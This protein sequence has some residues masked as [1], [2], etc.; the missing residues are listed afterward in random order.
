MAKFSINFGHTL[1]GAGCGAEYKGFNESEITRA[2]GKELINILERKGHIVYNSTIDVA[3]SQN[4]YLKKAVEKVNNTDVDI[5]ISLHCNAS[6]LHTG[7]GVEVFTWNKTKHKEALNILE[8]FEYRGF[9]NRGV[10]KGNNLYFIKNTKPK[11]LL[12]EMFFIDNNKDR[13]LYNKYGHKE[14]ARM[15]YRGLIQ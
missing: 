1:E 11:S 13:K 5:A 15:I 6:K 7:N 10:K 8:E 3:A 4:E 2:V 9:K 14:L 12:V